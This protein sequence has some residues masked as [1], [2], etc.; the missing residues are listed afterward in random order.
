M[1]AIGLTGIVFEQAIFETCP[2]S[3][4]DRVLM[5]GEEV[6]DL[7]AGL[8]VYRAAL[9]EPTRRFKGSAGL[10][11]LVDL[12][13]YTVTTRV[14]GQKGRNCAAAVRGHCLT[15]PLLGERKIALL[16]RF[17]SREDFRCRVVGRRWPVGRESRR[18]GLLQ[19]P[20]ELRS[21]ETIASLRPKDDAGE[22]PV[23]L[24]QGLA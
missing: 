23:E 15:K 4:G 20:H 24:P 2:V 11:Q 18:L 19:G 16:E 3:V 13:V 1:V 7:E 21:V 10:G 9:I 22:Q 8:S 5:A 12:R 14:G 6:F 17:D